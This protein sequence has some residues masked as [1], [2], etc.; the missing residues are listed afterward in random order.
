MH[1]LFFQ[2]VSQAF[3]IS[4]CESCIEY[5]EAV[6][7]SNVISTQFS[8]YLLVHQPLRYTCRLILFKPA[9]LFLIRLHLRLINL[10]KLAQKYMLEA[11][12]SLSLSVIYISLENPS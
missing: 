10:K 6:P 7:F 4:Y 2:R 3:I 9:V 1:E 5:N 11:D 8:L 12:F